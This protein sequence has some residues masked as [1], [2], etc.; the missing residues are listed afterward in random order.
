MKKNE[1]FLNFLEFLRNIFKLV[2]LA[3]LLSKLSRKL[4]SSA[5]HIQ[6]LIEWSFRNPEYFDHNIDLYFQWKMN[7]AAFPM[8]RGV[9]SSIAIKKDS[10]VLDLCCGDGFYSYYFYSLRAARIIG[11]DFD[12]QA[13]KWANKNHKSINSEFLCSDI[14]YNFPEG[15]FDNIIWD[16]AIEHFTPVE[17]DELMSKIKLSLGMDG[18]LSGYT[19]L[20]SGTGHKH[21]HQHEY[22]FKNKQDLARFLTPYFKNVQVIE[23]VYS[24]RTNLYFYATDSKLPLYSD[25]TLVIN[26]PA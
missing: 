15:K 16:A 23:T 4:A 19:V 22:E 12:K 11:V 17:I 5:H 20:E 13:I 7:R 10:R 1:Y 25:M 24:E 2:S 8:E 3:R 26:N 6:F 9:F 21:I 14:R 18:V